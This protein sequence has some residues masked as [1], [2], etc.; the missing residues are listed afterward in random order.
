MADLKRGPAFGYSKLELCSCQQHPVHSGRLEAWKLSALFA[1][2]LCLPALSVVFIILISYR[3]SIVTMAERCCVMKCRS[4]SHDD[5][6]QKINNGITFHP[7][8]AWRQNEHSQLS[9]LTKRR[10]VAWVSAVRRK[11]I[12]FDEIPTSA[13]VCSLHFHSG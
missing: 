7:F 12:T 5:H 11:N 6:G 8:P 3:P 2:A 13:R 4:A 10:R 1:A 9:E